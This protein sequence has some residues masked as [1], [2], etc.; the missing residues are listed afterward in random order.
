M[1]TASLA[2]SEILDRLRLSHARL[3]RVDAAHTELD[4]QEQRI[5]EQRAELK[6]EHAAALAEIEE[7]LA[8]SQEWNTNGTIAPVPLTFDDG[9]R[10]IGWVGGEVKLG[11]K[12]YRFVKALYFAKKQRLRTTTLENRVWGKMGNPA[13]GA[14]KTMVSRL[15]KVLREN[16]CPYKIVHLNY[17]GHVLRTVNRNNGKTYD[18]RQMEL[19]GYKLVAKFL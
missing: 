7:L 14:V 6:I 19:S 15:E 16:G 17:K 12:P 5:A 9:K 13:F 3:L 11:K 1:S 2:Q 10:T 18:A 4:K 8:L